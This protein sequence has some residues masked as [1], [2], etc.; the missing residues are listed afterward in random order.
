MGIRNR[1]TKNIVFIYLFIHLF[2]SCKGQEKNGGIW[3]F[4]KSK[5][6]A[7][8]PKNK[9]ETLFDYKEQYIVVRNDSIFYAVGDTITP[10]CLVEEDLIKE[11][12]DF[13]IN[14]SDED[15]V[16]I[17]SFLTEEMGL[18]I[19][20]FKGLYKLDCDPPLNKLFDFG[21]KFLIRE[22]GVYYHVFEKAK[23]VSEKSTEVIID[24]KNLEAHNL[25]IDYEKSKSLNFTSIKGVFSKIDMD[26]LSLLKLP[27]I[28]DVNPILIKGYRANGEENYCLGI[29]NNQIQMLDYMNIMYFQEIE[30]EDSFGVLLTSFLIDEDYQIT[31][32]KEKIQTQK[33]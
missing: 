33:K 22:Y 26:N 21:D 9:I 10:T 16:K 2:I 17:K 13:N 12:L 7:L 18:D 14:G 19:S 29:F 23:P 27:E 11:N 3:Y 25:P 31:I 15:R 32:K 24:I 4:T 28:Y 5:Q 8:N 6:F 30:Q 1:H 20:K